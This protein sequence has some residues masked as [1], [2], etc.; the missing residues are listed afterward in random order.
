[1][2]NKKSGLSDVLFPK[3]RQSLLGLLFGRPDTSF[4]TN[5]IIRLTHSGSGAVQRELD[6]LAKAELITVERKG[7]RKQYHAN[8]LSPLYAE[9]RG[10]VLKTFGLVDVLREALQPVSKDIKVAF[11]YGSVAKNEDTSESDIDLMIISDTLS[12]AELFPLL[13]KAQEQIGRE[14]NPT[15]YSESEWKRKLGEK[16]HFVTQVMKQAKLFLLGIEDELREVR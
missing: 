2:S 13:E 3:V 16:K 1:M 10:I 14:I 9:L 5:E 12:Y 11:I 4:H 8:K 6:K 15:F 7:N